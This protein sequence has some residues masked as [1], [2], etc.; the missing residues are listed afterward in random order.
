MKTPNEAVP[1]PTEAELDILHVLWQ[2]GSSTVR[3]V[4]DEMNKRTQHRK[5]SANAKT[6]DE[7][8][9]TTTLK[10]MQIM[11][12][13]KLVSRDESTRTHIYTAAVREEDVQQTMVEKFVQNVFRGSAMKLVMQ[14]LGSGET[15]TSELNELKK[16]I[17]AKQREQAV[18]APS[19]NKSK[20]G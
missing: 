18:N 13:K 17:E 14:A 7:I 16:L 4:N 12:E 2:H 5:N 11:A 20:K 19:A 10:I 8:G 15:S 3:F 6:T 1:K 9:Y